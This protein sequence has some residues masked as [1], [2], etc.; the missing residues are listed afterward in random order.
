[1]KVFK[2]GGASVKD[3]KSIHNVYEILKEDNDPK[4]VVIS[5]MGKT[6]NAL[7]S[8]VNAYFQ[9]ENYE[10]KMNT[11]LQSHI[12][13]AVELFENES[14]AIVQKI[15][16][17]I[18]S[19]LEFLN[20]NTVKNYD[21]IYDQTV[22]LGEILSTTI[23]SDYLLYRGLDS[24]WVDIRPIIKTNSQHRAARIDWELT[25]ESLRNTF[26]GDDLF[27]TQG[28]IASSSEGS[29]TTLGR[30]G[31]DYTAAIIAYALD[32]DSVTTWK[33]VPGIL[34]ADPR[35]FPEAELIV[36]LSYSEA[37]EM[38]Y[39]GAKVIHPKTIQPLFQKGIPLFVRSFKNPEKT[40]TRIKAETSVQLPPVIVVEEKQV[41]LKIKVNDLSFIAEHD[42]SDVLKV[43]AEYDIK[44][45]LLQ[46]A[47]LTLHAAITNQPRKLKTLIDKLK[48]SYEVEVEENLTLLTIR[49]YTQN[50][51]DTYLR[52]GEIL[53]EQKTENTIQ[54]L[55][56]KG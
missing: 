26:Y 17:I 42:I 8:I 12:D 20:Q 35:L 15:T 40:G 51:I 31:S 2:F 44:I 14:E 1:M 43:F 36:D 53:I 34:N 5:A 10:N 25:K 32:A 28:F 22:S 11:L 54:C 49:H 41:W 23:V 46:T 38:T 19:A 45:N 21:Y 27:L 4:V 50:A 9:D 33:D 29:T 37:I 39:Y 52:E 24:K 47:A 30:E 56:R 7:E 55:V 18:D 3:A 16:S 13:F 6:T 48:E